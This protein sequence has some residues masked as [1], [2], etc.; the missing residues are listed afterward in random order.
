M[1]KLKVVAAFLAVII[2]LV[3]AGQVYLWHTTS[4][5]V[6]MVDEAQQTLKQDQD[7]TATKKKL[8]QFTKTWQSQRRFLP[9]LLNHNAINAV[10]SSAARLPVY[11]QEGDTTQFLAE[12]ALIRA[13]LEQLWDMEKINWENIF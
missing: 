8:A 5:M 13:E 1:G 9:I 3:A 11:L 12:C 4:S 6:S 7:P 10:N 2:A